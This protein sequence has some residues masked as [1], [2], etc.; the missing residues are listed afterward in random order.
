MG[1]DSTAA[2]HILVLPQQLLLMLDEAGARARAAAHNEP[3]A[4]DL[5]HL[6][7]L[8]VSGSPA[9]DA[10]GGACVVGVLAGHDKLD[11]AEP[12]HHL[13]WPCMQ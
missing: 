3:L 6:V 1:V 7:A 5:L 11:E 10:L 12:R 8:G 2:Q 13:N 4:L 9:A